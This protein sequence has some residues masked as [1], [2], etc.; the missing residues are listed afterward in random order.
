MLY[1][2]FCTI[3][4]IS[5]QKDSRS[6]DYYMPFFFRMTSRV[7]YNALYHRQHCT[8]QAF[9]Q[10]GSLMRNIPPDR[11]SNLV[12]LSFVPQTDSMN[13]WSRLVHYTALKTIQLSKLSIQMSLKCTVLCTMFRTINK[14]WKCHS[15][16]S[17]CCEK[18]TSATCSQFVGQHSLITT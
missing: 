9:E 5:R 13:H 18:Q 10:F 4:A 7:L 16:L 3:M 6:R 8:L 11:D 17:F 12:P 2:A 15:L 14:P 1:V